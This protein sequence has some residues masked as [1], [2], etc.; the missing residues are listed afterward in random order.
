MRLGRAAGLALF[1]IPRVGYF[2]DFIKT[3]PGLALLILIPSGLLL[4]N[5]FLSLSR[6][7][8]PRY[9]ALTRR[10]RRVARR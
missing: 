4:G 5:E 6:E 1:A 10:R 3:F 2:R 8:N 7:S 9:K